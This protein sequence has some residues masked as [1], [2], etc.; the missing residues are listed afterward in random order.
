MFRSIHLVKSAGPECT[1]ICRIIM[2]LAEYSKPH[3]YDVSVL[4]LSSGPLRAQMLAARISAHAISWNGTCQDI[5]GAVRVFFWLRRNRPKIVHLHWGGRMVRAI[6]R[7][8]GAGVVVEHIHGRINENT[9]D[10]PTNLSFPWVNAVVACSNAVATSVSSHR[11]EVIYAGIEV[12]PAPQSLTDHTGPLRVGVLSRLTPIKNVEAVIQAA[13]QL[14]DLGVEIQVNI[15]GSGPSDIAL[16]NIVSEL[17]VAD[18]VCFLGWREDIPELLS[19]WDLLVMPSLDEGFPLSV[20]EAMAA[21]RPVL[22]SRVGGLP[23]IVL[24]G[25]TGYLIPPKDTEALVHH[26]TE[27]ANDRVRLAE[28]GQ[29]G[30]K[31]AQAE[32]SVQ[33]T[34]IHMAHFYDRLLRDRLGRS[35]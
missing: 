19:S 10:I 2:S 18:R 31:R 33:N 28:M 12:N 26:I 11:P 7:L 23:E 16:R 13:A 32:F 34:A 35:R 8:A 20:L 17:N 5:V 27:L 29:A 6:C 9:G 14:R 30:W 1:G 4:F 3:G 24:D 22:A 21:A 15:A 25:V